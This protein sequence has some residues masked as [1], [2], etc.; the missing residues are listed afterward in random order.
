[1][2]QKKKINLAI[3]AHVDSGKTS[4][5]EEF[6][7]HSG[8]KKTLGN[9]DKGTTTTDSLSLE[10][11]RGITIRSATVSFD[12]KDAKINLIDTPGHM[13]FIAEVERSF[14]VLDGVVLV[15]SAKEG[16]Q[17]QTREI[18]ERV[19]KMQLPMI[20]FI[21][22]IDRLGVN[23]K[24]V[25]E[26]IEEV[27]TKDV[28][29][30]QDV[31]ED[32]SYHLH[33]KPR[34]LTDESVISQLVLYSETLYERY[35]GA[36]KDVNEQECLQEL[37]ECTQ[38]AA[39][40]PVYYGSAL[41]D[42]GIE[43]LLDGIV[44]WFQKQENEAIQW[45]FDGS[46]TGKELLSKA[47]EELSA[48]VYKLEWVGKNYRKAYIR[49]Y[50]GGLWFKQRVP[51]YNREEVIVINRYLG[52]ENGKEVEQ[53][54]IGPGDICVLYGAGTLKCGQWLGKPTERKGLNQELDPL[55]RVQVR[56]HEPERRMEALDALC[57]LEAEDPYLLV[58]NKENC[59][60]L[61]LFGKLQKD[62]IRDTLLERYQLLLDFDEV[63]TV[64]KEKPTKEVIT[65][66]WFGQSFDEEEKRLL[67][68]PFNQYHA[69][70]Q[71]KLEPLPAGN[72]CWYETQVSFGDL[73]K[74]FQ[75]A[76]K[77]GALKALQKGL[78]HEV[79]DAKII[80]L[81]MEY[82]SVTSTP[83][84]YRELAQRVVLLA[85]SQ[86]EII[87][88]QPYMMYTARVPLGFER[89][90]TAKL[91]DIHAVIQ[92]S[93]FTAIEAV[94]EGEVALDDVKDFALDIK[95]YTEGKGSF[96]MKFLEYRS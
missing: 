40:Y 46:Y 10:K 35:F 1:M 70:I 74:S 2:N 51:I 95:M 17:P 7:Y 25:Q 96:E 12:W 50:S 85:L 27:L 60:T 16:V 79:I 44:T 67:N 71:F 6:L 84:D 77:E 30:L 53:D 92:N 11:E 56:P 31:Y 15:I 66:I 58:E 13:D 3:V 43:P 75:N 34:A 29:Y 49:V 18:F 21:N 63:E 80:F 9:V 32:E 69:G 41:K 19:K 4:V 22:K 93:Y 37:Y 61:R 89:Y 54:I 83:A 90:I 87:T 48:Y 64:K 8:A 86:S 33:I 42:I 78:N 26:Q 36:V 73:E 68:M 24:E 39:V 23:I 59:T 28:V 52:L 81:D 76:V 38:A 82:N 88:I 47:T 65:S 57:E 72:G 14:S 20:I 5:T 94:Y 91:V 55:L 45:P 62:I